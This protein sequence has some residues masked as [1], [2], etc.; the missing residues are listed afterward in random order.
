MTKPPLNSGRVISISKE[1]FIANFKT[2]H[3]KL[4]LDTISTLRESKQD[5]SWSEAGGN[6]YSWRMFQI[7]SP[8][9]VLCIVVSFCSAFERVFSRFFCLLLSLF[10][11]RGTLTCLSMRVE[12]WRQGSESNIFVCLLSTSLSWRIRCSPYNHHLILCWTL[13]TEKKSFYHLSEK[14]KTNSWKYWKCKLL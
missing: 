9:L 3:S 10:G 2:D 1:K 14:E 6:F 13:I 7:E 4:M 8:N 12:S 11:F 5:G